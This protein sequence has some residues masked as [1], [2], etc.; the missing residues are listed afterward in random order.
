MKENIISGTQ[1]SP[2]F[3]VI[4]DVVTIFSFVILRNEGSLKMN[5]VQAL[6]PSIKLHQ[7]KSGFRDVS[8]LNMTKE[9]YMEA[10]NKNKPHL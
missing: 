9:G 2:L 8:F 5:T 6:R 7:L 4:P 10:H 1:T 3:F